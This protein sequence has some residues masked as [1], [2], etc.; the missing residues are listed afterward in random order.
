M[1]INKNIKQLALNDFNTGKIS[2]VPNSQD[3]FLIDTGRMQI[4]QV[5]PSNEILKRI[6]LMEIIPLKQ[7]DTAFFDSN[8]L[9]I[10]DFQSRKLF[11]IK[12]EFDSGAGSNHSIVFSP[13]DE[14]PLNTGSIIIAGMSIQDRY[15]LLDK[16]HSLIRILQTDFSNE[17]T[18]GSRMGYII[19]YANQENVRLGFEFPEDM[20]VSGEQLI[21]SD[22]G[23]KRLVLLS[24][25]NANIKQEK[26]IPLPE[27]PFKI[28]SWEDDIVT[29]SDFDCSVMV[30]SLKYGFI[31]MHSIDYPVDFFPS[32]FHPTY[33]EVGSE[34]RNTTEWVELSFP[35]V[36]I[37]TL[38]Q[39]AGNLSVLIKVKIDQAS[40]N[41]SNEARELVLNNI[42]LLSEYVKYTTDTHPQILLS[43]TE[44]VTSV[45]TSKTEENESIRETLSKLAVEFVK[46]YKSIPQAEDVE[47]ANIDKENIRHRMFLLI[48]QYRR[49]LKTLA[50][51][52]KIIRNYPDQFNLFMALSGERYEAV[53]TGILNCISLIEENLKEFNEVEVP[54]IIVD[55]WM[56]SE[57]EQVI[58]H[59]WDKSFTYEKLFGTKF[60]LPILNEFYSTVGE[61]FRKRNKIEQYI[62]FV[63][64]EITMFPDRMSVFI[65][66]C[67]RLVE[68]GKYDDVLRMLKKFPDQNK[69]YVN[70]FYYRVCL[71]KWDTDGAFAHLKKEL[72]LYSHRLEL[73]PELIRLNKLNREEAQQYIDK[74]LEKSTP[75]IDMNI[76]VAKAFKNLGDY[77]R[78]ELY[79][80]REFR[81][82]PENKSVI[83]LKHETFHWRMN[84]L[85]Q[86]DRVEYLSQTWEMFKSFIRSCTDEQ[87]AVQVISFF[88]MLNYID[89]DEVELNVIENLMHKTRCASYKK[90]IQVFLSFEKNQLK[91]EGIGEVEQY[92]PE[93]YLSAYST[94]RIS[95]LFYI[96]RL[97][98]M[99][100]DGKHEDMF[101]LAES[102]L[103]YN[104][105]DEV[106]FEILQ[107]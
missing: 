34:I 52:G 29:V 78:F 97:K 85:S 46:K 86:T 47:A 8:Y 44:Y 49:N 28:L 48:K 1:I 14:Y 93:D 5:S 101:P 76:H 69:E 41:P 19:E 54:R 55:Y 105:G 75:S 38:A 87:V 16:G 98:E 72:D 62:L 83:P 81:L 42:H 21:V 11:R 9:I 31:A 35:Q 4:L 79:L 3:L 64:K 56:L 24:W 15:V 22:S 37:E 30:V 58:Y 63:D 53:K 104:P 60:L 102:L 71:A 26:I 7:I 94:R 103:K 39:E 10:T 73:I 23:N 33:H 32:S 6:S 106:I 80:D 61:L 20:A 100:A 91:K 89:V 12:Y 13:G 66:F 107:G 90:E 77:E 27:Y 25:N 84:T 50:D 45:F 57:E 67:N 65:E 95:Y 74:I 68:L 88:E 2:H 18:I 92:N 36:S 40:P 17:T 96:E 51:T 70:Y 82:F 99:K 59:G 43:L